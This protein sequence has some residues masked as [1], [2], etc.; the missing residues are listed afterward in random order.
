MLKGKTS[1]LCL[2]ILL[3]TSQLL[4]SGNS[5]ID[6]LRTLA[7]T[8]SNDSSRAKALDY[9][10]WEYMNSNVDS[11]LL[12][13]EEQI[14]AA[15]KSG[16]P[17]ILSKAYFNYAT[18]HAQKGLL[19]ESI[20]IFYQALEE[21][22]KANSPKKMSQIYNN[23]GLV[24]KFLS[25]PESAME[26][27]L[28]SVEEYK[29][30]PTLDKGLADTY[31][32]I[33][34][35]D[36]ERGDFEE[37]IE[38]Y[39]MAREI[40][41]ELSIN[42][43]SVGNLLNNLG[44][45]YNDKGNFAKALDYHIRSMKIFDGL[46]DTSN[47]YAYVLNNIGI[48]YNKQED[49]DKALNY[50]QKSAQVLGK[51][52]SDNI[53]YGKVLN[54]IGQIYIQKNE[55]D[56][57]KMIL[58]EAL[59]VQEGYSEKSIHLANTYS[60]IGQLYELRDDLNIA[61]QFFEKSLLL[62]KQMNSKVSTVEALFDLGRLEVL[63]GNIQ[64]GL[65]LCNQSL[66]LA[67]DM[68]LLKSK[69]QA[70]EC[71]YEGNDKLGNISKAYQY[72]KKYRVYRD[73]LI[74]QENT[75]EITQKTM[76]YE[77]DKVQYQDSL[78]RAEDSRQRALI[79]KEKDIRQEAEIQKQ[80]AYT[81]AGGVGFILMLGLA[82]VLFRG[83][84]NKQKANEIIT[85][86]KNAVEEQKEIIEEKNREIVD[87]IS[88]AQRI[89]NAILPSDK[90]IKEVLPEAFVYFNPKD[91]VSGDFYWVDEKGDD[92]YFAAVDCTGHG[93]PGALVSVVGYNG[94]N[95]V[96]HEF[97]LTE[98][99]PMLDK[100]NELVEETFSKSN[101]SIKDGMDLGLCKI[102][103]KTRKLEFAGA[104][105]PLY[106]IRDKNK[107]SESLL[108]EHRLHE[109]EDSSM[110]LLEIKPDKQPI[111]KYEYREPFATHKLDLLEGDA[112][113]VFSD[114]YADQFGGAK[115]KKFMYKP[116]KRMLTQMAN[117]SMDDQ[118]IRIR[119]TFNDWKGTIEQIDDV[120]VF[121][122]R[123]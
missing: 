45:I 17:V 116:F 95:R 85:E 23:L 6:S 12:V 47:Q 60:N 103:R 39:E 104:N 7:D 28:R 33:G 63:S 36:M 27:Y 88:Y 41:E 80:R 111:G 35:I 96:L 70:C 68:K 67:K 64:K 49:Y 44:I 32:N 31:N 121:G 87:S 76:Q 123:V 102:N 75:K 112:I 79:Q 18:A 114:G 34:I 83:Y 38:Y 105:N 59:L 15:K 10:V 120:C 56:T 108:K 119:D 77:F 99:G 93:V 22:K 91:I 117:V 58:D 94:L 8:V 40:Y 89:Q 74:N 109:D 66:V 107:F 52:G 46:R 25:Q 98:P 73:S 19:D 16:V 100:L 30:L 54:N 13:A 110:S 101:D 57:A 122:V 55:L 24:Y 26:I 81:L 9:L 48:I 4:Y 118:K 53:G 106:L 2:I 50:F 86:Q 5:Q 65:Q 69:M 90:F 71:I 92:V 43:R 72:Y 113:Y 84:K 51:V 21:A 14:E 37:A 78:R 115:G 61:K 29:K 1:I 82:F 3:A 42:D 62:S 11:A 20:P 97:N